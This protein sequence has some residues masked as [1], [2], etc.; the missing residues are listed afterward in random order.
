M[1]F[2]DVRILAFGVLNRPRSTLSVNE[3]ATTFLCPPGLQS[4]DLSLVGNTAQTNN[5]VLNGTKN[6]REWELA[7]KIWHYNL[8]HPSSILTKQPHAVTYMNV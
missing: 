3:N 5:T 2:A 1:E 6:I 4:A 8:F 7:K